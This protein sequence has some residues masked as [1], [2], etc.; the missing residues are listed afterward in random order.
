MQIQVRN[1]SKI[2]ADNK[3]LKQISFGI[4]KGEMVAIIGHNGAGKSTLL[5]ILSGWLL[6]DTGQIKIEDVG[7]RS[8]KFA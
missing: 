4:S 8:G 3:G 5:K 2:Y 6:S 7:C 1:L